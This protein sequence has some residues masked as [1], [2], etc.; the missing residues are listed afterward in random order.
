MWAD[1]YDNDLRDSSTFCTWRAYTI[2]PSKGQKHDATLSG[3]VGYVY[4]AGITY[5]RKGMYEQSLEAYLKSKLIEGA[6]PEELSAFRTAY[7]KS[8]IRGYWRQVRGAVTRDGPET[9]S[10]TRIYARLGE[11]DQIIDYLNCAFLNHCP[12][13]RT[14]KVDS[15]YDN[16][17][18]DPKF[19]EL[20]TRLNL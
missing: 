8:D 1:S 12:S 7:Q 4:L 9:C 16:L 20:V 17:R 14:L 10:M 15:F 2:R 18:D 5:E 11:T 19:K 13:I 6:K 3:F